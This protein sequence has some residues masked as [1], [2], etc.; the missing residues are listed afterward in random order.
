MVCNNCNMKFNSDLINEVKGGCNPAPIQRSV[1]D[2][3][4]VI[5]AADLAQGA[6]Y[7]PRQ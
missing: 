1:A 4:V 2:G 5:A 3:K 7:F 6:K